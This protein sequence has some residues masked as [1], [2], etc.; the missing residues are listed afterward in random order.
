MLIAFA[1][2]EYLPLPMSWTGPLLAQP[3]RSIGSSSAVL[4]RI[5]SPQQALRERS[6]LPQWTPPHSGSAVA[7]Q[8]LLEFQDYRSGDRIC[9]TETATQIVEQMTK[10]IQC[11]N[12]LRPRTGERIHISPLTNDAVTLIAGFDHVHM[13]ETTP[14]RTDSLVGI[15]EF[16]VTP[17]LYPKSHY[18]E[19]RHGK[20]P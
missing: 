5:A 1:M 9:H 20:T 13:L 16:L 17:T 7:V 3:A 6:P 8:S 10:G 14:I 15:E 19:C 4:V 2:S 11:G 12:H 18:I